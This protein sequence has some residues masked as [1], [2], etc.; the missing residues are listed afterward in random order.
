[1]QVSISEY[2]LADLTIGIKK[3]STTPYMGN[4]GVL[5]KNLEALCITQC[6]SRK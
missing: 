1:M 3:R 2:Q 4:L 5:V 6:S